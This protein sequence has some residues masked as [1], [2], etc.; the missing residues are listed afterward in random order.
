MIYTLFRHQPL[1]VGSSWN[2]RSPESIPCQQ[3]GRHGARRP[4]RGQRR[5]VSHTAWGQQND[6]KHEQNKL[7]GKW[8]ERR[9]QGDSQLNRRALCLWHQAPNRRQLPAPALGFSVVPVGTGES[10]GRRPSPAGGERRLL[11]Q[12]AG[13]LENQLLARELG[14]LSTGRNSSFSAYKCARSQTHSPTLPHSTP[15]HNVFSLSFTQTRTYSQTHI[16]HNVHSHVQHAHATLS[17]TLTNK[18]L[19][20]TAHTPSPSLP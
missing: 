6:V 10:G 20:H 13:H 18:T 19:T 9:R 15:P 1:G 5:T 3:Q 2:Q 17:H 11:A 14:L 7:R 8:L 4:C 12:T 16:R